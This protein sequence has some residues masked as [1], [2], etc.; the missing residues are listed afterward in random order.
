MDKRKTFDNLLQLKN[1]LQTILAQKEKASF[2]VDNTG[3]S[4]ME[5][6]IT[7]IEEKSS[8]GET[9][10]TVNQTDEILLKEIIAVNGQFR[11]DYSEC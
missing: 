8:I 10:I 2:L 1:L 9:I 7:G 4:R 5:G 11:S 6:L 3:I